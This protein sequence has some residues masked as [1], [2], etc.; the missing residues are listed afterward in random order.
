[1]EFRVRRAEHTDLDA[2]VAFT[3]AEAEAA[4]SIALDSNAVRRGVRAGL[5]NPATSSYWVIEGPDG[6]P[7]GSISVVREWS[8]W[9]AAD[10]WWIQSVFVTPAFRGRGLMKRLLATVATEAREQGALE[11][12]LYVHR[13]NENA[14][15]A[16][17]RAGFSAAPYLV[18]RAEL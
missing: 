11:L 12:R 16:Y 13:G 7:V 9:R 2:L 14:V 5:E 10:Y 15:R 8:D 6:P 3:L 17:E 1:M 4:E 18:M